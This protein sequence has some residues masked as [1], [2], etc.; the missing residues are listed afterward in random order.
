[1]DQGSGGNI[2]VGT[3]ANDP[4]TRYYSEILR[5]EGLNQFSLSDAPV[6]PELLAG[7]AVLLLGTR[8]LAPEET[9]FGEV[10]RGFHEGPP[11]N[12]VNQRSYK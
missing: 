1:M 7:K 6:T 2:L 11:C 3:A 8:A 9:F 5:A 12:C 4:F 10:R